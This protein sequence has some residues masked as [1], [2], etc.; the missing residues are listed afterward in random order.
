MNGGD[1]SHEPPGRLQKFVKTFSPMWFTWCMNAGILGLLTHQSP[2]QFPGLQVIS[3]IFYIFDLVLFVL[4]S[5]LFILR[6]LMYRGQ[7][8]HA[9]TADPM[10]IMFVACWPSTLH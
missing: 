4:F 10:S 2:Y 1:K 5:S 9:I 3:T 7:A 6:F 8:Y